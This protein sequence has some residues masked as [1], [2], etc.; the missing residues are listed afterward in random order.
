ME[1][2]ILSSDFFFEK[3]WLSNF[4]E[5]STEICSQIWSTIGP[6]LCNDSPEGY[7]LDEVEESSTADTKGIL[8]YSF[9]AIHESR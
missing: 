6:I 1:E 7:L 8:S 5:N 2:K 9:R 4:Q 3:Q